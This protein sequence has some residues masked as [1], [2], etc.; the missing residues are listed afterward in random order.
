MSTDLFLGWDLSTQSLTVVAT[1]RDGA[2]VYRHQLDFDRDLPAYGTRNGCIHGP[3]WSETDDTHP[4]LVRS[5]AVMWVDA[6]ILLLRQMKSDQFP[7]ERVRAVSGSAQQHATVYWATSQFPSALYGVSDLDENGKHALAEEIFSLP[8]SPIWR[9]ASTGEQC[10]EMKSQRPGLWW[11][12]ISGSVPYLRFSGP[13][14]ARVIHKRPDAFQRTKRIS[15]VSS[16]FSSL[17]CGSY[18]PTDQSDGS[19]MNLLDLS[20][21]QWSPEAMTILANLHEKNRDD[22]KRV[23]ASEHL[24]QLL[25]APCAPWADVGAISSELQEQFGFS[26]ECRV[27]ACSGDNPCSLVG[28]GPAS[29]D[30]VVSLGTS[31]TVTAG[32]VPIKETISKQTEK[33]M[34]DGHLFVDPVHENSC[35]GMLCYQNGSLARQRVRDDVCEDKSWETF[36]RYLRDTEPGNQGVIGLYFFEPEITPQASAGVRRYDTREDKFLTESFSNPAMEV[37][38]IVESQFMSM[39]RHAVN[40]GMFPLPEGAKILATGGASENK[41]ILQVLADVFGAPV[42]CLSYSG[43]AALGA[44]SRAMD[45]LERKSTPNILPNGAVEIC[46]PRQEMT[47]IYTSMEPHFAK[48]ERFHLDE[49][50]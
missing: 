18:A 32:G 11:R 25:D 37:R 30:L 19:G 15:L 47:D 20:T 23:E 16:F 34:D 3:M 45:G 28:C 26:K 49:S 22:E 35:M 33:I 44:A 5:P 24:Q 50:K 40:L 9:D 29:G 43:S 39:R 13:Q 27:I 1:Q 17:L 14:I 46:R 38:A 41:D 8:L 48:L 36:S 4:G 10:Q 6:F 7:F 21:G 31:D 2:V 42:F 12:Q